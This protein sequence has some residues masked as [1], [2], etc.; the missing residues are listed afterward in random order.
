MDCIREAV[1]NPNT[2]S[3]NCEED[4]SKKPK[5]IE[6]FKTSINS[7]HLVSKF[8]EERFKELKKKYDNLKK[9]TRFLDIIALNINIGR[10]SLSIKLNKTG[11]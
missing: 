10:L 2:D 1:P 11:F 5:E 4:I 3:S 7:I 6:S 8:F 9:L